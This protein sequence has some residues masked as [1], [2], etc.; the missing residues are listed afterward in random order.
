MYKKIANQ[1]YLQKMEMKN[2]LFVALSA[3]PILYQNW[4]GKLIG[5]E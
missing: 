2:A 3:L 1:W 5:E 4:R